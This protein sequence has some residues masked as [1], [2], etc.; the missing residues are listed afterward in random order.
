MTQISRQTRKDILDV[1]AVENVQ[2]SGRLDEVAFLSRLFDLRAMQSKDYRFSNAEQD[3]RQHRVS[4]NDGP[5]DWV[6]SDDR[7]NLIGSSD[8]LFLNFLLEM[9]HPVVRPD[10]AESTRLVQAFNEALEADG[11]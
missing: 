2:W 3:I 11:F 9:V 7:F 1:L 5:D 4:W 6:F 8:E 10:A